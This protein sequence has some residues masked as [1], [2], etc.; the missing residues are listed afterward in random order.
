MI[1]VYATLEEASA[2]PAPKS[3]WIDIGRVVVYTGDD[4][5]HISCRVSFISFTLCAEELGLIDKIPLDL[6]ETLPAEIDSDEDYG[7]I[8][9]TPTELKQVFYLA[10]RL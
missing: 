8:G 6:L 10:E 5:P 7:D 3:L 2:V 1:S 9:L 4:L